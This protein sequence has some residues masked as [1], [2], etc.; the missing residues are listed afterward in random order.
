VTFLVQPDSLF[1]L[2]RGSEPTLVGGGCCG[3]I[4]FSPDQSQVL[5][6]A[7]LIPAA[8]RVLRLDGSGSDSLALPSDVAG[9]PKL[10]RWDA[11]GLRVVYYRNGEYRL[12]EQANES[13]HFLALAA[14]G[15]ETIAPDSWD[16]SG[17]GKATAYWALGYCPPNGFCQGDLFVLDLSTGKATRVAGHTD[18][19]GRARVAFSPDG[20]TVAY[21]ISGGLYLLKVT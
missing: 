16:W 4:A 12:Y 17:D 19:D 8:F 5:C 6:R 9:S 10:F 7:Q 21:Y 1:L 14:S 13:T 20:T 18:T 11:T 2:R 3:L 15:Q